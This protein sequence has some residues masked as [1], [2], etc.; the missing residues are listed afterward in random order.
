MSAQN[1]TAELTK[2]H[3]M[4]AADRWLESRKLFLSARTH[5]KL[6]EIAS[7][8]LRAYQQMQR[9]SVNGRKINQELGCLVQMLKRIGRWQDLA[10]DYQPLK[11]DR[12]S[13]GRALSEAEY[14]RLTRHAMSRPEWEGA[15]L[16]MIPDSGHTAQRCRP[17]RHGACFGA[18]RKRGSHHPEH[19]LFPYRINGNAYGGTYDPRRH[20]T[21]CKT[22]WKK[23][24]N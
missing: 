3:F 23:L 6:T 24:T 7:D 18:C 1:P 11:V 14:E 19:Y 8:L 20:Q 5:F 17:C 12:R 16:F 21:T 15:Y 13:P 22:A 9:D 2:V 4:E 10:A